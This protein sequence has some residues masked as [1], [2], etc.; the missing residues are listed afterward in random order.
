MQGQTSRSCHAGPRIIKVCKWSL[1]TRGEI[2]P[3]DA[4]GIWSVECIAYQLRERVLA[5]HE[6]VG[7]I[8]QVAPGSLGHR[9]SMAT[10]VRTLWMGQDLW[11]AGANLLALQVTR[12]TFLRCSPI[13][14]HRR[15]V[16]HT[17][18]SSLS[19]RVDCNT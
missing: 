5:V 4:H 1:R 19:E 13:F 9:P 8:L 16:K 11:Y 10:T 18:G 15:L 14:G 17:R 6:V 12:L 2:G 3:I 7:N